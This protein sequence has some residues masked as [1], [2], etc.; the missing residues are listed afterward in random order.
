MDTQPSCWS[1]QRS[2]PRRAQQQPAK[3]FDEALRGVHCRSDWYEG[4]QVNLM[5][6]FSAAAPALLGFDEDIAHVCASE[7]KPGKSDDDA[8]AEQARREQLGCYAAR[9][10]DVLFAHCA[11]LSS[12]A[13]C[14]WPAVHEQKV[15][16]SNTA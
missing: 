7:R 6:N 11:N 4:H 16:H 10:P 1:V 2:S 14:D 8:I 12:L 15:Q 13:A 5:P 9:Y 3:Y